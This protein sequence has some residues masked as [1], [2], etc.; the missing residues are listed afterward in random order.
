MKKW[1]N[2]FIDCIWFRRLCGGY[3]CKGVMRG[4]PDLEYLACW[5]Q[6]KNSSWEI[7]YPQN[8]EFKKIYKRECWGTINLHVDH[9]VERK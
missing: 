7:N 2:R 9:L 8:S 5:K 3:W 4:N 1:V 6:Y